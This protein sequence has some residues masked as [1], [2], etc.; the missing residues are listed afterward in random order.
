MKVS[1][2]SKSP[3]SQSLTYT[4]NPEVRK[5]EGRCKGRW[6]NC[7][8]GCCFT[9]TRW[10]S[11]WQSTCV[12][13]RFAAAS[14]LP[15]AR[16][17]FVAHPKQ[18]CRRKGIL[19]NVVSL[20]KVTHYKGIAPYYEGLSAIPSLF[21]PSLIWPGWKFSFP[22]LSSQSPENKT[23]WWHLA[24][25]LIFSLLIVFPPLDCN[26]LQVRI[27]RSLHCL[28]H[29]EQFIKVHGMNEGIVEWIMNWLMEHRDAVKWDSRVVQSLLLCNKSSP[30]LSNLK[31]QLLF[32][33]FW[34]SW[35]W[36][37]LRES[38]WLRV[39]GEVTDYWLGL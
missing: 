21:H 38:F 22:P 24:C 19:G 33:R 31:K 37:H 10:V 18:K 7:R 9:L 5:A 13:H 3:L 20:D 27:W 35:I 34:E 25:L 30:K 36:E 23:T 17:S 29:G 32:H 26:L 11:R 14:L 2:R 6:R 39:S 4:P 12:H 1:F 28:T 15:A 16:I 8:P